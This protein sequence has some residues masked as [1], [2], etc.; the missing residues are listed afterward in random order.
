MTH[1]KAGQLEKG[2][3]ENQSSFKALLLR[4]VKGFSL[5][6]FDKEATTCYQSTF[7]T[8]QQLVRTDWSHSNNHSLLV[9]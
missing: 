6:C 1:R 8:T 7:T 4:E 3:I 5:A 2:L 9:L